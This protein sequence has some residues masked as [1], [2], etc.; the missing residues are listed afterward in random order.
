MPKAGAAF[1]VATPMPPTLLVAKL[2][3]LA[4][5][6]VVTAVCASALMLSKMD[7]AKAATCEQVFFL[8]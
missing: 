1:V 6:L 7:N 3:V 2:L 8:V 5:P 4:L